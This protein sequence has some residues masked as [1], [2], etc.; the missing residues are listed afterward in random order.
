MT[1][2][3]CEMIQLAIIDGSR[4][5]RNASCRS[6]RQ[7]A[8]M[9]KPCASSIIGGNV[10][11]IVL[12]V[13]VGGHDEAAA[14]VREAGREAGGLTEVA[15]EP[16][17]AQPRVARLQRRQQLERLI[18]AAVVDDDDLVAPARSASSV[19]V[20]S[21]YSAGTFGAS[22]RTGMT[23]EISGFIVSGVTTND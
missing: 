13:A 23:T 19:A 3:T 6:L 17:D 2:V 14:G 12:Q 22:L 11:R 9:S 15:A 10:A 1:P 20:S 5:L 16:D 21:S 18:R 8:T 4:R 7:P